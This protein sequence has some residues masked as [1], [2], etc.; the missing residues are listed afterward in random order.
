M[1]TGGSDGSIFVYSVTDYINETE[2]FKPTVQEEKKLQEKE[3]KNL[4]VDEALAD[5]VLI[6]WQEMEEWT[7]KQEQLKNE[8][9]DAQHKLESSVTEI[10][11]WFSK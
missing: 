5:V 3:Y 4:I 6:K 1:F 8:M 10:K 7:K 9:E 2:I 11:N